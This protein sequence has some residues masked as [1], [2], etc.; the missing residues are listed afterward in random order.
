MVGKCFSVFIIE[1]SSK[2]LYQVCL[3][4]VTGGAFFP[5][6]FKPTQNFCIFEVGV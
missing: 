4:Q 2:Q 6:P 3:G 5:K 1:R